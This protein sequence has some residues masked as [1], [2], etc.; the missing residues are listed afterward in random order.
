MRLQIDNADGLGPTDYTAACTT[1]GPLEMVRSRDAWA[2]TTV[3]LDCAG[4]QVA[5]PVAGARVTVTDSNGGLLFAGYAESA[6]AVTRVSSEADAVLI[7]MAAVEDGWWSGAAVSTALQTAGASV[8]AVT[9][10]DVPLHVD[11]AAEVLPG[12]V[13]LSGDVEPV[14]Y[15]T[16]L[17]RGDGTTASFAL[18]S[19]VFRPS[20]K[21]TLLREQFATPMLDSRVW[22]IAD[23]GHNLSVGPAGLQ[24]TPGGATDGDL[25]LVRQQPV[26]M[27]GTLV[28]ELNG[29][30]M[31]AGSSG[32][33]AG[34]FAG[35]WTQASCFAGFA[36]STAAGVTSVSPL[37]NG[38]S[39]GVSFAMA[40]G[41]SYTLRLRLFCTEWQ[42]TLA[43]YSV[44]ADGAVVSF[45]GGSVSAPVQMVF[46][47]VDEGLASNT[48]ATVLYDGAVASSPA[49]CSFAALT[50]GSL[51]GSV[52]Q[53]SVRQTAPVRVVST[54]SDGTRLTRREG[55][56]GQGADF[57]LSSA[58]VVNFFAGVVP[59]PGELVAV[60]YRCGARAVAR[61]Q[62]AAALARAQQTGSPGVP[63]RE[64]HVVAPTARSSADCHAAAAALVRL[65]EDGAAGLRGHV[66]LTVTPSVAG[67]DGAVP[68]PGDVLT[69]SDAAGARSLPVWQVLAT[70]GNCVPEVIRCGVQ[71][72]VDERHAASFRTA[73]GL[74]AD[75]PTPVAVSSASGTLANL[76]GLQVQGA[77]TTA[78]LLDA[79]TD[80]PTGGGFEVRRVDGAFQPGTDATLVLRSTTRGLTLPRAAFRERFFVRMFDG[81]TPP[82]YSAVS[83][84]VVTHLPTG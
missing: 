9:L 10:A 75:T 65:S 77:T 3:L 41:H 19:P 70:D 72:A 82:R 14:T 59:Q 4:A 58:G 20:T 74:A 44:L 48:I 51:Q 76:A 24:V 27:G 79:G 30:Q 60:S 37:V 78:V 17:F 15:V 49:Q 64:G 21:A 22:A 69:W 45:G 7:R 39:A 36:V 67:G 25:R 46:E 16:E 6:T 52:A 47:V 33:L 53:V 1:D 38:A 8:H 29:V 50:A 73:A 34:M 54:R 23:A 18:S 28:A 66:A 2:R 35:G 71:F 55:A 42:R 40:A 12:D 84:S 57:S 68:A 63:L 81:A 62:S 61:V 13:A 31:H 11:S 43:T 80:A 26:E 56:T 32:V 83:S 5:V